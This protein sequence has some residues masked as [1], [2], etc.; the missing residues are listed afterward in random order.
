MSK[1]IV[2][3]FQNNVENA[4]IAENEGSG[5]SPIDRSGRSVRGTVDVRSSISDKVLVIDDSVSVHTTEW[6][7]IYLRSDSGRTYATYEWETL[8]HEG[9][10]TL[11]DRREDD[12][13]KQL[14]DLA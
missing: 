3:L 2:T 12:D 9:L 4:P 6:G 7:Q 1:T 13:P 11:R 5:L 8:L 14:S 10:A